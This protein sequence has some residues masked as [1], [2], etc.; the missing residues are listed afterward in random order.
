MSTSNVLLDYY[1]NANDVDI[2]VFEPCG[3]FP[4]AAVW[5]A[6]EYMTWSNERYEQKLHINPLRKY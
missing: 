2:M 3:V 6:G 5:G 4:P 1:S